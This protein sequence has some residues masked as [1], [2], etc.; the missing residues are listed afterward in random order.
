MSWPE[1]KKSIDWI[2]A[3]SIAMFFLGVT[4]G[5]WELEIHQDQRDDTYAIAGVLFL[6][7]VAI[8]YFPPS[9]KE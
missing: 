9:K 8:K 2:L 4:G 3:A 7:W 1:I 6:A 5:F